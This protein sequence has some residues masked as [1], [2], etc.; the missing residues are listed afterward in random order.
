MLLSILDIFRGGG[1]VRCGPLPDLLS[2]KSCFRPNGSF[3]GLVGNQRSEQLLFVLSVAGM[4]FG[5]GVQ[6]QSYTIQRGV[7]KEP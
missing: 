1:R 7:V 4:R 5:L 3:F 2:C 6:L